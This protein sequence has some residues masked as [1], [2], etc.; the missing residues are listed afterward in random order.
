MVSSKPKLSSS[1][2]VSIVDSAAL[3]SVDAEQP[4]SILLLAG[5]AV[6]S[7]PSTMAWD[8]SSS[9][10]AVKTKTTAWSHLF[11]MN[12]SS[13]ERH[14]LRSGMCCCC[15]ATLA[16]F[17]PTILL[18]RGLLLSFSFTREQWLSL[19]RRKISGGDAKMFCRLK[20]P[21]NYC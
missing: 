10:T 20:K 9:V 7:S 11:A 14:C 12:S 6:I 8:S 16:E 2:S 15:R 13:P 5:G 4:F 18:C 3:D 21:S 17:H 1:L 19:K